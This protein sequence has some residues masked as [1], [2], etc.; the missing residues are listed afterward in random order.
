MPNVIAL[1]RVEN[2]DTWLKAD[3]REKLFPQFCSS[4]RL[5]RMPGDN[6]V[7]LYIENADVEKMQALFESPEAAVAKKADTVIDP[8]EILVELESAQ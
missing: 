4:Y 6:R 8:I 7:A 2:M 1:H 5:F 3:N